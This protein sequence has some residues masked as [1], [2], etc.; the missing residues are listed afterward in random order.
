MGNSNGRFNQPATHI[1]TVMA[2]LWTPRGIRTS[3]TMMRGLG[4]LK[5][6]HRVSGRWVTEIVDDELCWIYQLD[7][8]RE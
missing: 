4:V 6:A 3:V 8:D 7:A 5:V 2:S 1:R